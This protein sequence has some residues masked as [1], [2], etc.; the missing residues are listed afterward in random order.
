M[1]FYVTFVIMKETITKILGEE[2]G[3]DLINKITDEVIGVYNDDFKMHHFNMHNYISHKELTLH[4]RLDGDLTIRNG[5]KIATN[6]E[7]IIKEKF[8]IVATIRVEPL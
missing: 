3:E 5:H 8:N 4:I 1:L 6:I 2:P 7:K